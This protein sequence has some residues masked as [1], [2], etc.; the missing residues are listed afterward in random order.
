[1]KH[2]VAKKIVKQSFDPR[3]GCRYSNGLELAAIR[4]TNARIQTRG[5][6]KRTQRQ[7]GLSREQQNIIITMPRGWVISSLIPQA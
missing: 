5:D 2:R 3:S 4:V 7:S 1:M 6:R